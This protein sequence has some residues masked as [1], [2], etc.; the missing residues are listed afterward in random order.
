MEIRSV[1]SNL[2]MGQKEEQTEGQTNMKKLKGNYSN[3]WKAPVR[4]EYKFCH[5]VGTCLLCN[6]R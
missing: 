2:L 6:V 3:F 5:E 1:G 4:D